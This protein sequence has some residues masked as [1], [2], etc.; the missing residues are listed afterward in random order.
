MTAENIRYREK[1]PQPTLRT[2]G[3]RMAAY[4]DAVAPYIDPKQ[5]LKST[6][7]AREIMDLVAEQLKAEE[8]KILLPGALIGSDNEV[9]VYQTSR[10]SGGHYLIAPKELEWGTVYG[11]TAQSFVREWLHFLKNNYPVLDPECMY[12]PRPQ[13]YDPEWF[14]ESSAT[15]MLP[16]T[17]QNQQTSWVDADV[18]GFILG[19]KVS[20]FWQ[21]VPWGGNRKH[22]MDHIRRA[23]WDPEGYLLADNPN[24][25]FNEMLALAGEWRESQQFTP[26][27]EP[28]S[29]DGYGRYD[30]R[31]S[32]DLLNANPY[33]LARQF[34]LPAKR[35][36]PNTSLHLYTQAIPSIRQPLI[37]FDDNHFPL[38]TVNQ[39]MIGNVPAD[40]AV[41]DFESMNKRTFDEPSYRSRNILALW[42]E[43]LQS[44]IASRFESRKMILDINDLFMGKAA[45]FYEHVQP[46]QNLKFCNN[47]FKFITNWRRDLHT[48]LKEVGGR[49][50]TLTELL[51]TYYSSM[52]ARLMQDTLQPRE[53]LF[54]SE[55]LLQIAQREAPQELSKQME[56]RKIRNVYGNYSWISSD[57]RE[58]I[59]LPVLGDVIFK[60]LLEAGGMRERIEEIWMSTGEEFYRRTIAKMQMRVTADG[61]PL[62]YLDPTPL[63]PT[64]QNY[65]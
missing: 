61:V 42:N 38:T 59:L 51:N 7:R 17:Q 46:L 16:D 50:L 36:S 65:R 5:N 62:R 27:R 28:H 47:N 11:M 10:M 15:I 43:S 41:V 21:N 34:G 39:H 1:E 64:S 25:L 3:E 54:S 2:L 48:I 29:Y 56:I 23:L 4:G 19:P 12:L 30:I 26:L 22:E 60:R 58:F 20:N 33:D 24:S 18:C 40:Q 32:E 52:T 44:A 57:V 8:P 55:Q 63:S 49:H 9:E 31:T 13:G 14:R 35:V 37:N 45:P 53:D 6:V